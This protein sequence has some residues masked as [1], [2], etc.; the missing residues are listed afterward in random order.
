MSLAQTICE[1]AS[2]NTPTYNQGNDL[3]CSVMVQTI[4]SL[5]LGPVACDCFVARLIPPPCVSMTII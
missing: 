3:I 2:A 4:A 1:K 5:H